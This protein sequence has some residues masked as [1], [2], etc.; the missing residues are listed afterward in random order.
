MTRKRSLKNRYI[1]FLRRIWPAPTL[2][3]MMLSLGGCAS[4]PVAGVSPPSAPAPELPTAC[5]PG[6]TL[7]P[8]LPLEKKEKHATVGALE[9]I[10]SCLALEPSVSH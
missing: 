7:P 5:A 2:A 8:S 4:R 1:R 10:A 3:A 9:P 6:F